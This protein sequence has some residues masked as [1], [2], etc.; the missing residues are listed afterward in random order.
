MRRSVD[1][2]SGGVLG[3][4]VLGGLA[5]SNGSVRAA[6][7]KNGP[8]RLI[9]PLIRHADHQDV[10]PAL[11]DV[12]PI[13][14]NWYSELDKD[15]HEVKRWP[16]RYRALTAQQLALFKDAARQTPRTLPITPKVSATPGLNFDGVG[17]PS[18][19]PSGAP[20]DTNGAAGATQYVQ[21]VNT[22]FAVFNKSTGAMVYGPA[23]G[24]T[25]W[26]GFGGRCQSDNSGD[27]IVMYDQIA[28]RWLMMQFAVSASPFF[29]CVAVSQTSDATGAWNRYSYQFSNFNDYPKG[30]SGPTPTTSPTTCSTPRARPSW[31]P[32]SAPWIARRC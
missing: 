5:L 14:P 18:Y 8:Q 4:A 11:R 28:N 25:L 22:A 32:R 27:P 30:A 9:D 13:P 16:R 15:T 26:S 2:L 23:A 10:L 24:N 21:W 19:S 12:K 31:A 20:P 17:L 6:E 3:V 29:Q 7:Q 1:I